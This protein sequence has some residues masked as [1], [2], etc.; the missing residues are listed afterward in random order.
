MMNAL[1]LSWLS[2]PATDYVVQGLLAFLVFVMPWLMKEKSGCSVFLIPLA[3]ICLWGVWRMFSF[4]PAMKNDVPGIGYF[5]A[6]FGYSLIAWGLYVGKHSVKRWLG[7]GKAPAFREPL[8]LAE[9]RD[10]ESQEH[11][12]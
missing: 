11:P 2:L 1:C 8:P 7:K 12:G 5:V 3:A 4:D 9:T 6:A 10:A